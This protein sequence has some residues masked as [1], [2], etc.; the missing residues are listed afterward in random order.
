MCQSDSKVDI[1]IVVGLMMNSLPNFKDAS[2]PWVA[3]PEGH[4]ITV[5]CVRA[6]LETGLV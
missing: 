5:E 3:S 1:G 6:A 2:L 4:D